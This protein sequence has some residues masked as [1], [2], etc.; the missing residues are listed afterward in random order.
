VLF[1][2]LDDVLRAF[3]WFARDLKDTKTVGFE[4]NA[5]HNGVGR[6]AFLNYLGL[7]AAAAFFSTALW[8]VVKGAHNYIVRRRKLNI[9]WLP[10]EF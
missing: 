8:G 9:H 4:S 10:S 5:D 1:L 6:L 3:R 2:I 7:G